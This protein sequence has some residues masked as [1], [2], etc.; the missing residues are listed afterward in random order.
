MTSAYSTPSGTGWYD[1]SSAPTIGTTDTTVSGGAD[2]QFVFTGWS[3]SDSGGY[4]GVSASHSVTMNGPITET[5]NW[6]TQYDLTLATN[7]G[8]TS[9]AVGDNWEYAGAQVTISATAPSAGSGEQYVRNSWTGTGTGNSYT[10]SNNPASNAVT[11]SGPVTETASWTLEYQIAVT[12]SDHGTISPDTTYVAQGDTP[13]FTIKPNTGYHILDVKVDSVSVLSSLVDNVYTFPAVTDNHEISA[14]FAINTYTITPSAGD[15]GSITPSA[16]QSVNYGDDSKTFT[17]APNI[18]YHIT[19]VMAGSN[20]LG[21]VTSYQYTN[22]QAD[23]TLSAT[24]AINTYTITVTQTDNGKIAPNTTSYNYGDSPSFTITPTDGYYIASITTDTGSI[25][26]DSPSGQTV[27]FPEIQADHT[28]TATYALTI[29]PTSIS[30]LTSPDHFDANHPTTIT[31]SGCLTSIGNPLGSKTV[32]L[33]YNIGGGW[34]WFATVT[35]G[36]RRK[37]C[38]N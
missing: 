17:I 33:S 37:I 28:I 1:A 12:Q 9:P 35:T 27:S 38:I 19:D 24:F 3:S 10:G 23:S 13:I 36:R 16:P 5:A 8:S 26:V 7:F 32:T 34:K 6:Q 30:V 20:D 31:V 11:T 2:T 25:K 18:G 29:Q 14:T 4:S 22:V 21:V 15:G